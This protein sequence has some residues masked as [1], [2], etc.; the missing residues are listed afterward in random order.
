LYDLLVVYS[1]VEGKKTL[2]PFDPSAREKKGK[3]KKGRRKKA[4]PVE[5]SCK[6]TSSRQ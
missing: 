4:N 5:L 3:R 2:Y 6:C 1:A